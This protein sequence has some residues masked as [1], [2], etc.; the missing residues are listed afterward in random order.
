M[1]LLRTAMYAKNI[2]LYC[3]PT[4]DDRDTWQV[5][6]RHIAMEGRCFVLSSCQYVTRGAF[7]D[8]YDAIQGNAPETVLMRGGSLIVSPL[9]EILAGPNF[10][11]ECILTADLDLDDIARGKYDFDA[12]GHYARPD[13]FRLMVDES[14]KPAVINSIGLTGSDG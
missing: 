12:V 10:D 9:G 7:P 1:P 2:Q 11:G 3:A 13:I 8:D 14:A 5:T 6:M 4:A